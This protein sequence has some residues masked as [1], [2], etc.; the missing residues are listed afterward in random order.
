MNE[1]VLE[2]TRVKQWHDAGFTGKGVKIML[3]D[4]S[5]NPFNPDWF[6][7]ANIVVAPDA[8]FR[9]NRSARF[10]H[11]GKQIASVLVFAPDA[12]I[13][14]T[15]KGS[16]DRL[17]YMRD[18]GIHIYSQSVTMS[19]DNEEM[20]AIERE[21]NE[22]GGVL[23]VASGN[24]SDGGFVPLGGKDTF[25]SIGACN[26]SGDKVVRSYYSSYHETKPYVDALF[27]SDY[28]TPLGDTGTGTSFSCPAFAGLFAVWYGAFIH[29]KGRVPTTYES[30]MFIA[31]NCQYV[32]DD[33]Q[34]ATGY[35]VLVMPDVMKN[36]IELWI[37]S[38]LAK[39]NGEDYVLNSAP[40]ETGG[41][42]RLP[43]RDLAN[44]M[45]YTVGFNAVEQKITLTEK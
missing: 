24:E 26:F 23:F 15:G 32:E 17:L 39:V 16:K 27:F 12:E 45:G 11:Y 37:G 33:N 3:V 41:V 22:Q 5:Y 36:V 6:P 38:N 30:R 4:T 40:I 44:L 35:G 29:M 7:D 8:E 13:H 43:V 28:E 31:E 19:W 20:N 42:T 14:I 21:I 2:Y 9:I 10:N 34:Y 1:K 18:N 25:I